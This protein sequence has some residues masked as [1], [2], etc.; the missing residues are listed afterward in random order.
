MKK[1]KNRY[2]TIINKNRVKTEVERMNRSMKMMILLIQVQA[3]F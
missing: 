3:N 2:V 1:K